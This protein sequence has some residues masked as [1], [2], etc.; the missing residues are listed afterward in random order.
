MLRPA[1][2]LFISNFRR[3]APF[4]IGSVTARNWTKP[5]FGRLRVFLERASLLS[6][7]KDLAWIREKG[8]ITEDEFSIAKRKLGLSAGVKVE[9]HLA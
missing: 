1:P 7:A 6:G 4:K 3:T 8:I 5:K 2:L 9:R